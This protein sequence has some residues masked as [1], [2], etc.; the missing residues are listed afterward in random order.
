MKC[1]VFSRS[2]FVQLERRTWKT[3]EEV[4]E[5]KPRSA[6]LEREATLFLRFGCFQCPGKSA[7]G[8]DTTCA[9]P[10]SGSWFGRMAEQSPTAGFELKDLIE[11]S[12]QHMPINFPS[13]KNSFTTDIDD[14]PTLR[15]TETIEAGQLTS[16]LFTEEREV[17]ANPFGVAPLREFEV[18]MY[19]R[20]HGQT[21][22]DTGKGKEIKHT[23]KTTGRT[24]KAQNED[25][26]GSHV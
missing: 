26:L 21:I 10:Q 8:F 17:S 4:A 3:G 25:T 20:Q 9:D 7:G 24:A 19:G 13:R 12:G 23:Q 2:H 5:E 1:S 15:L 16:P 11:I 22:N 14:V 6:C 18:L